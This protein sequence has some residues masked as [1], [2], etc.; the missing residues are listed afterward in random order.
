MHVVHIHACLRRTHIHIHSRNQ[1][2]PARKYPGMLWGMLRGCWQTNTY[3]YIYIYI[4]TYLYISK[5]VPIY[6][7]QK[8]ANTCTGKDINNLACCRVAVKQ[9]H[10][11]ICIYVYTYKQT[12]KLVPTYIQQKPA[13]TCTGKEINNLAC[14]RAAIKQFDHSC[15]GF[16]DYSLRYMCARACVCSCVCVF[17]QSSCLVAFDYLGRLYVCV[18]VCVCACSMQICMHVMCSSQILIECMNK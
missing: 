13:N 10:M 17:K 18:C 1:P 2:T 14:Y 11:H 16:S 15:G 9:I 4:Y 8:P 3:A 12:N 5:L 6:I 7:Q